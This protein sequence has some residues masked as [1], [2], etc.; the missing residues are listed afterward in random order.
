M[1]PIFELLIKQCVHS[2]MALNHALAPEVARH[3]LHPAV[4]NS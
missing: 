4:R 3:H 2:P 1:H